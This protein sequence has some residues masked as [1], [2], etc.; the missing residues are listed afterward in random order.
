MRAYL[1]IAGVGVIGVAALPEGGIRTGWKVVVAYTA[2]AGIVAGVALRRPRARAAWYCLAAG[3]FVN[4]SGIIVEHVTNVVHPNLPSP[5][6]A[7]AFWLATYPALALGFGLL[8][9]RREAGT[10]GAA[11]IDTVT[12]MT[13]LGLLAWVY[14]IHPT[15][16]DPSEAWKARLVYV[17]YPI[18]DIVLL[19]MVARF[20]AGAKGRTGAYA[21]IAA[22][23]ALIFLG[24]LS[25]FAINMSGMPD[26]MVVTRALDLVYTFAY[27][28]L[29]LAALHP[30]MLEAEDGTPLP[31]VRLSRGRLAALLI[32]CLLAPG[33]LAVQVFRGAVTDGLAIASGSIALFLLVVVRMAQ[34]LKQVEQQSSRLRE[35][36][37]I[38]ELTGLP[39]RRAWSSELPPTLERARR[40]VAPLCIA[41]IDLDYFKRFND[42][43]G[44]PA[45]DRLLRGA[46][47]AWSSQLRTVDVLARYGGEEFI[48][49]LPSA[50]GRD[51]EE[52]VNRLRTVT[53]LGQTFSSGLACW[54]GTETSDELIARAD[55]ALYEAKAAGRD[56]VH[57]DGAPTSEPLPA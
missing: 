47:A 48:V 7:D 26:T 9:H 6:P 1:I 37:R 40:D 50:N 35:L 8:I 16:A 25:W 2:V 41:M 3:A 43:F 56:R 36:T 21:G 57:V 20:F 30:S 55:R 32:A 31:M 53:P 54:D 49:L 17:S 23:V 33:L 34:L 19:A 45:G 22:S 44:H 42:E 46:A 51:A 52:I 39:N 11:L 18:G 4:G 15:A 24:D 14:V 13:G 27:L 38:D 29:G 5:V 10:N 12:I 28:T